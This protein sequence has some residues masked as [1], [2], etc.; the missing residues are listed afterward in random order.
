MCFLFCLY[1]F[2]TV[3][4][5]TYVTMGSLS[6]INLPFTAALFIPLQSIKI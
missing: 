2:F 1:M 6:L 3:I 5:V 4:M